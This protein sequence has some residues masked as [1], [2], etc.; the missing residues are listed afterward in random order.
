LKLLHRVRLKPK[1]SLVFVE[2]FWRQ[3]R[4]FPPYSLTALRC[5]SVRAAKR[6]RIWH[7]NAKASG[8][9]MFERCEQSSNMGL[10]IGI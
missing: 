2:C 6:N 10:C 5:G 4:F 7:P 8:L 1:H 3:F 9:P